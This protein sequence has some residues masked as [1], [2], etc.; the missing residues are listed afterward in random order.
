[1]EHVSIEL[2]FQTTFLSDLEVYLVSPSGTR[3]QLIADTG[4]SGDYNGVW[5]FGT[6]AFAGEE[7]AGDWQLI[8]VDDAGGDPLT[9]RDAILRTSGSAV[10]DDDLFILT[11][12][13]L[14]LIHI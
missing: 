5:R 10:S 6:T 1:M 4:D 9:I 14:S 8:I 12:E 13:F 7:S 3:V 2:D 11:N